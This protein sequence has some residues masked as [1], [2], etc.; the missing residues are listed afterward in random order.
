MGHYHI[1]LCETAFGLCNKEAN[2]KAGLG[3]RARQARQARSRQ[4]SKPT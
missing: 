4:P 2:P 3:N 1:R